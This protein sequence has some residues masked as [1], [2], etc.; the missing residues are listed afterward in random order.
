MEAGL[1]WPRSV[2]CS[3]DW[4]RAHNAALMARCRSHAFLPFPIKIV[5]RNY[6][7]F[8]KGETR[9]NVKERFLPFLLP[10]GKSVFPHRGPGA[11]RL[12]AV[13]GGSQFRR[14]KRTCENMKA[15][16]RHPLSS[17]PSICDMTGVSQRF[18]KS[19][20]LLFIC[21]CREFAV[22]SLGTKLLMRRPEEQRKTRGLVLSSTC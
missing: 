12:R 10:I 16:L 7:S 18:L 2:N 15:G 21:F 1:G 22:T 20:W 6:F 13:L 11:L 9:I 4:T 5:S 14:G 8:E 19:M 3:S 17:Q